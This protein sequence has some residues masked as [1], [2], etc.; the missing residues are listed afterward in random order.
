MAIE[1]KE[2]RIGDALYHVTQL[3]A[4]RALRLKSKLIKTFG[5]SL[6]QL[7]MSYDE[8]T[9]KSH[10][11]MT[12]EEKLDCLSINPVDKYRI[13]EI[14]KSSIVKGVQLLASSLDDKTFEDF[15]SELTQ[16][17]R[18]DGVE[19]NSGIIDHV[20][21]GDLLNL[22]SVLFFILEVNYADFFGLGGIGSQ[23]EDLVPQ[24]QDTKKTYTYK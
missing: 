16:G 11:E 24:V 15:V 3:P 1:T 4:R 14:R 23:L 22:Y 8:K 6:A 5:P 17:V 19:L 10:S 2:K 9:E 7:F 13:E 20:F 21:A 12:D 18:R